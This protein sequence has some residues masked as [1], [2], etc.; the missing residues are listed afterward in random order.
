MTEK[1]AQDVEP[2]KGALHRALHIP[3]DQK[4]PVT[5]ERK[6]LAMPVGSRYDGITVT[7]KLKDQINFH[8]NVSGR[9]RS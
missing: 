1:W 3:T 8:L 4:I 6:I 2:K 7:A 5:E 9:G